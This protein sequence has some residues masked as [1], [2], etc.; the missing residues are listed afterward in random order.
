MLTKI[1]KLDI[2]PEVWNKQFICLLLCLSSASV[3]AQQ[4]EQPLSESASSESEA[5]VKTA[6]QNVEQ[7]VEPSPGAEQ[8][9]DKKVEESAEEVGPPVDK[10]P[11][12]AGETKAVD[13]FRI[14]RQEHP[15][16][17]CERSHDTYDYE[18]SWY[19]S[20]QISINSRFCEPALWFDNF[21][22]NDRIFEEGAAG[23]YIRWRNEFTFD[24]EESF[25]FKTDLSASV[26]LPGAQNKLRLTYAADEDEKLR[27]I[28]PGN[29]EETSNSLGVQLDLHENDRSKFNVSVSFSPKILLRYRYTYPVRDDL[30]LRYTQELERNK[31]VNKARTLFDVEHVFA[32][33][34]LFASSTEGKVSEEF[35]G[36]DWLQAF[37]VYQRVNKKTSL[38]Y[39]TS[40]SGVTEPGTRV[41]NYR[42]GVRF[43]K[44]FHREWLFYEIAPEMTWP[45][46]FDEDRLNVEIQRRSKWMLFFRLEVHFGNASK[47][48]YQDYQ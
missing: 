25:K 4:S 36:V 14:Y 42:L 43:R 46:T 24:E 30:I 38:S 26:E 17:P 7:V 32:Q 39:E 18:Q 31:Q 12:V 37:V 9:P 8:K 2:K 21:F 45:V 6:D 3:T 5:V 33:S 35:E 10:E 27:D 15:D 16:N 40:M 44:N 28:A 29:A 41:T 34:F 48:R 11:D 19:D 13:Q 20:S 47:K 23:T 1:I 22:A